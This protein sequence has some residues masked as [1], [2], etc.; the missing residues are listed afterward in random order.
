MT[1]ILRKFAEFHF[2]APEKTL[3]KNCGRP[4]FAIPEVKRLYIQDTK[5]V[6]DEIE[7]GAKEKP[8]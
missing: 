2:F 7:K 4:L 6:S 5:T 3:G 8:N 1:F